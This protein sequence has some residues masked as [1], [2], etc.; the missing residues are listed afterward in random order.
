MK[1]GVFFRG[2]LKNTPRRQIHHGETPTWV[3]KVRGVFKINATSS[4]NFEISRRLSDLLLSTLRLTW[5]EIDVAFSTQRCYVSEGS[6]LGIHFRDPFMQYSLQGSFQAIYP[7][8]ILLGDIHLR[9]LLARNPY[10]RQQR[11]LPTQEY[12]FFL[13]P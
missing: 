10:F 11:F 2:V 13:S 3:K 1:S 7:L 9:D 12:H 5:M 6:F 8:G 4:L